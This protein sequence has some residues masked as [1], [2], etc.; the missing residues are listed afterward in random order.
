MKTI[1]TQDFKN[2][3]SDYYLLINKGYP[4]KSTLTIVGD[5]YHLSKE[6]RVL[7]YRGICPRQ[8]A[9]KRKKKRV[10]RLRGR[11]VSID[12]YNVLITIACYLYGRAVYLGN[13]GFLRDAGE[14]FG[15]LVRDDMFYRAMDLMLE[16]LKRTSPVFCRLYIDRPVS[17]SGDFAVELTNKLDELGIPGGPEVVRSP[18][19]ILKRKEEGVVCTSDSAV[20]DAAKTGVYDLAFH[21]LKAKFHPA[22]VDLGKLV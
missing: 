11:H 17:F 3:V 22:V 21:I 12:T 7:L 5:H 13:D 2:G 6:Q 16:F 19:F 10:S 14:V 9:R 4:E 1:L 20:I 15:S 18:D 8:A